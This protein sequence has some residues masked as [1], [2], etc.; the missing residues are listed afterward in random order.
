MM[1]TTVALAALV[2]S[3]HAHGNM[4]S[5]VPR[6]SNAID[7]DGEPNK[8]GSKD[9]YSQ[10][11]SPGEY[12][13]LGCVGEACLWYQIG[14]FVGCGTC[15][16]V[17]KDL[18]PTAADLAAAGN[19]EPIA[20]TLPQE[21][22]TYNVDDESSHGDWSAVNPWRAPGTA[23]RGNPQFNPCGVSS[24]GSPKFPGPPATGYPRG[25][26]GTDLPPLKSNTT[27]WKAGSEQKVEWGIYAN[28]GGGY[29][30]RL[31]K[32]DAQGQVTEDCFQQTPL[33]FATETTEVHYHDNS[34]PDFMINA[35][36]TS[37]GTWPKG[38]QWRRNPIPMCGCDIGVKCYSEATQD[39]N[40]P[41]KTTHLHPGQKLDRCP[42]GVMFETQWD[43]GY[44]AGAYP[45][46]GEKSE[47]LG[48]FPFTMT[49]TVKVPTGLSGDY[50]LSW[51]WDCEQTPQVWNSCADISI[52]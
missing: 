20:P 46:P 28:H 36:S 45:L 33:D 50:M 49:D 7:P 4:L 39:E 27:T 35:T 52:D 25:T 26:P 10:A 22:R 34:R 12:C 37:I 43:D 30:F 18:Y 48:A 11:G 9:P 19:C 16:L 5:P 1:K 2:A 47:P 3:A 41:Y 31:C 17:G 24:G 6:S 8:C 21:L 38:S 23:G 32:K 29:S 13:G 15:S 14:C 40:K 44:G 42:S 51:R